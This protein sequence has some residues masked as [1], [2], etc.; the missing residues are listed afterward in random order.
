MRDMVK[1]ASYT[2]AYTYQQLLTGNVLGQVRYKDVEL[3][4][5]VGARNGLHVAYH[6]PSSWTYPLSIFRLAQ[7]SLNLLAC[8][9]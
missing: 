9:Q 8:S 6:L 5:A 3:L 1:A 2:G 7:F 4:L